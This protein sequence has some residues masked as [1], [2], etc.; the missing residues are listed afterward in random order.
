VRATPRRLQEAVRSPAT[1]AISVLTPEELVADTH[2]RMRLF[3]RDM[4]MPAGLAITPDGGPPDNPPAIMSALR[5]RA[6]ELMRRNELPLCA[7]SDRMQRSK[8]R[9]YSITSS[10]KM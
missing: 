4:I 10:A 2:D 1:D 6:T 3:Y 7:I 9:L 8:Q 5:L